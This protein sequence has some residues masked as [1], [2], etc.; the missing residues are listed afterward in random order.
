MR[1]AIY[2]RVST[3][4]QVETHTS[5]QQRE[6]LQS[7]VKTQG[8]S[9]ASD[10]I[11]CD[12]GYSGATLKRPG[13]ERLR[14][15]VSEATLDRVVISA[16]DRLA[17]NYV[18]QVLLLEE[19]QRSGCEVEFLDRPMSQDPHDQLLLQIRGAVAEY[20]RSLI[21]ERMRRGRQ[22]KLQAGL[23]LPWT[24]APYGYRM[25]PERPRDPLGLRLEAAEAAVVQ[26][27]FAR[28]AEQEVSLFSLA[29]SLEREGIRSPSGLPRW[30]PSTLRQVLKNP[31][32]MGQLYA[33]RIRTVAVRKR[34]SALGSVS[35]VSRGAVARPRDEWIAVGS[36]PAIVSEEQF[37]SVQARLAQNRQFAM[38]NSKAEAYL[39]RALVSCGVCHLACTGRT[40]HPDYEYYWCKGKAQLLISRRPERCPARYIPALQ[41]D[42]LVWQDLCQVLLH[43][44]SLT[45]ALQRANG[46]QWLPQDLQARR[47]QFRQGQQSLTRQQE[48]LTEAY[49]AGVIPLAEYRRRRQELEQKSQALA[50]QDRRFTTQ[51][52]RCAE[53]ANLAIAMEDFCHRVRVGLAHASFAHKRQLVEL[54]IDRVI[55]TNETV[56]IRYVI[57]TSPQGEQTRFS[58]LH[59]DY[60]DG[61][62][63]MSRSLTRMIYL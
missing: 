53:L 55:V 38:R 26:T 35:P 1:V 46:E 23:L 31:I 58:Y 21:A 25:D 30:N 8:W 43:P 5:E 41:L 57:P 42:A 37:E 40:M 33:N 45:Q 12:E 61:V 36:A 52:D 59:T 39:L 63:G 32:Y 54:L 7:Y 15:R 2:I 28:Y 4:R 6:R 14:D 20:E 10:A 3:Q 19:F 29:Q 50:N 34:G 56:E 27:L 13:L 11:F 47:R 44:E 9:L 62:C 48:R 22:Q 49:L 51:V 60:R 24:R 18:Q 16:P 17:R